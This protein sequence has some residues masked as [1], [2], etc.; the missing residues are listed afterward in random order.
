MNIASMI[1]NLFI[2]AENKQP[3]HS[4]TAERKQKELPP[5]SLTVQYTILGST[6]QLAYRISF[7]VQEKKGVGT[8]IPSIEG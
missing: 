6:Y 2:V 7:V 3:T 1:A 8:T 4:Y 5:S